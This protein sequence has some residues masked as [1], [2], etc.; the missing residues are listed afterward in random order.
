MDYLG[1]D[2]RWVEGLLHSRDVEIDGLR[3]F[4]EAYRHAAA[5]HLDERGGPILDWLEKVIS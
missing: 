5:A 3:A 2:L 4:L 1:S